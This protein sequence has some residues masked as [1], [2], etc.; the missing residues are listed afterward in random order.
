[1]R[2][3]ILGAVLLMMFSGSAQATPIGPAVILRSQ[4]DSAYEIT[5]INITQA[6]PESGV[7]DFWQVWN[8]TSAR[9]PTNGHRSR[10]SST[11][12]P[13]RCRTASTGPSWLGSRWSARR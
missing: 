13:S 6:I 4:V 7:I 1:M 8:A 9:R 12:T 10:T 5:F 3:A 2:K 11:T